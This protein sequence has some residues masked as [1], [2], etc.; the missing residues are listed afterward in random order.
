LSN[1][2]RGEPAP[3]ENVPR[4]SPEEITSMLKNKFSTVMD[5]QLMKKILPQ[6]RIQDPKGNS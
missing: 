3:Q 1:R 4:V 2:K 6:R 5:N